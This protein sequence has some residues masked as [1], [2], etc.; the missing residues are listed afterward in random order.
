MKLQLRSIALLLLIV[1]GTVIS[2]L[3]WGFWGHQHINRSA[4]FLLPPDL[5][6][7]YKSHIE[8]ISAHA[9]DPDKRRYADPEE[10]ARHYID[11]DRY[12]QN[13]FD[14]LPQRWEEAVARYGEDSLKAHGIVPW[15]VLRMQQRLTYAFREKKLNLILRYSADIGHYIADAHVP[16]HCTQN[17]NGQLTGQHGI[18][19]LWESR[20]PELLGD[21]YDR[22]AGT[23]TYIRNPSEKIW[24]VL[25]ESYAAHDSVLRIEKELSAGFPPDRKYTYEERGQMLVKVYSQE[26]AREYHR[27]L[28]GMVERRFKA[29]M[30][31]VASFWYTAWVNAGMPLLD[32]AGVYVMDDAA[33]ME[34]DS[35]D[36]AWQHR[37]GSHAGHD[38]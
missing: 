36:K 1:P 22:L 33:K 2:L 20:L 26:Y 11:L 7:F 13:P 24:E 4:V 12:G 5:F 21:N 17:Y 18:H 14:S 8:W 25:K 34:Q 29:A 28:N 16:L 9:V 27:R 6:G 32:S 19:G 23:C 15:H 37:S 30:H 35:L 38:D 10:A 31:T 3:A